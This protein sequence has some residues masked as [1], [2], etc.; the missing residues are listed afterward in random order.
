MATKMEEQ[1]IIVIED[2]EVTTE[3]LGTHCVYLL[4]SLD[5]KH[6]R[7]TYVGYT[8]DPSRRIRQH[9]GEISGGA[10]RTSKARPWKMVC[11]I[12]GFPDKRTALQYEWIN[13]HPKIKRWGVNGRIT[14]M[15][16]TL[17]KDKFTKTSKP[18]KDLNLT[19]NWLEEGHNID[20]GKNS[21]IQQTFHC[22]SA[23]VC[24]L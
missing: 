23:E 1:L 20:L 14:T 8:V 4:R 6:P 22:I 3:D 19:I 16:E 24:H 2:D 13:N 11:Y 15:K 18:T 10:K 12:E 21:K 5:P 9:N 17:M 7:K